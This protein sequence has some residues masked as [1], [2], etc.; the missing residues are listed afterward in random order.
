M[1]I[2][3]LYRF[4]SHSNDFLYLVVPN[5]ALGY[6]IWSFSLRKIIICFKLFCS[7]PCVYDVILTVVMFF[8]W[9]NFGAQCNTPTVT[10]SPCVHVILEEYMRP[11]LS[12]HLGRGLYWCNLEFPVIVTLCCIM[13][14]KLR[15]SPNCCFSDAAHKFT[16]YCRACM[17]CNIGCLCL[18]PCSA[19]TNSDIVCRNGHLVCIIAEKYMTLGPTFFAAV[20]WW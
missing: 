18:A 4:G 3:C 7:G 8:Q 10:W 17:S 13:M 20:E 19:T 9:C 11:G 6:A 5:S 2:N 15:A 12:A 14:I 16:L 1:L